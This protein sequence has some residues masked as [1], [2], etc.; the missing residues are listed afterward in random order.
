LIG[1]G[2]GAAL[3]GLAWAVSPN[4][5]VADLIMFTVLGS[6]LGNLYDWVD[7]AAAANGGPRV[8]SAFSISV[9]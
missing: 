1:T 8:T 5:G 2:V 9:P 6:T 7:G 4:G 3:G